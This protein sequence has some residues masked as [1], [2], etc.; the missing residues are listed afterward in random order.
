MVGDT[1]ADQHPAT[2]VCIA[3]HA[4]A[5]YVAP[6][7]NPCTASGRV[8]SHRSAAS[9]DQITADVHPRPRGGVTRDGRIRYRGIA[10]ANQ[11]PV[12]AVCIAGDG[13]AGDITPH[14]HAGTL[15]RGISTQR[16]VMVG[17]VA[18]HMDKCCRFIFSS[19]GT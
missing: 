14:L 13:S 10:A 11:H 1:A 12:T 2:A 8:S 7:F 9:V 17:Q 4:S 3:G 18:G 16:G 19:I 5:R 15:P 6:Q